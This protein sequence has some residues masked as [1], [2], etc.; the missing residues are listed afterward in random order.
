M[1]RQMKRALWV[2]ALVM[3]LSSLAVADAVPADASCSLG[4]VLTYLAPGFSCSI[5]NLTFSNFSYSGAT[6]AELHPSQRLVSR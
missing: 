5:G 4:T 2:A 1:M 3:G 6:T